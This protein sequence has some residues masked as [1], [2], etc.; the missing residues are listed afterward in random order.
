MLDRVKAHVGRHKVAYSMGTVVVVAGVA[1]YVGT[2]AGSSRTLSPS[3]SGVIS[4]NN[5]LDQTVIKLV[6]RPGPPSWVIRH[7]LRLEK[8]G[9]FSISLQQ[10]TVAREK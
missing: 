5:K 1:Y 2:L 7:R 10:L 8:S 9:I 6:D 3:I 4:I